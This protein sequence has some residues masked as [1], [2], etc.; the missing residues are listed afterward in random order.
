VK[1]R[2]PK[3]WPAGVR[4][5]RN[6]GRRVQAWWRWIGEQGDGSGRLA[7]KEKWKLWRYSRA[8]AAEETRQAKFS[9]ARSGMVH[10]VHVRVGAHASL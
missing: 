9:V 7:G 5:D 1:E 6:C 10:A 8:R 3:G 2:T 4:A